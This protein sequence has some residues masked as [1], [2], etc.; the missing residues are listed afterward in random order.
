MT[1]LSAKNCKNINK[2][3]FRTRKELLFLVANLLADVFVWNLQLF[4]NVDREI[5]RTAWLFR[6]HISPKIMVGCPI[7]DHVGTRI[8]H[9]WSVTDV[10]GHK[11]SCS[12]MVFKNE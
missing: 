1:F 9:F 3:P 10:E 12:E 4:D 5:H 11:Q 6:K 2:C 8:N 7:M